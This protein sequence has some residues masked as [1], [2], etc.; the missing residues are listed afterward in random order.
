MTRRVRPADLALLALAVV[1]LV[2]VGLTLQR[3]NAPVAESA[4]G[5]PGGRPQV[6]GA[7]DVQRPP[8]LLVV[9]DE[10]AGGEGASSPAQGFARLLADRLDAPYSVDAEPDTG[11][12]ARGDEPGTDLS[13]PARVKRLV[14]R[15]GPAPDLVV[16]EGGHEDYAAAPGELRAAVGQV[17]R[18]LEKA[19][20]DAQVVLMGS[21]R[22]FPESEVLEPLHRT[23]A[24]GAEEAGVPFVDPV[25]DGWIDADN[26]ARLIS[27]DLFHPNDEG[28]ALLAER[29]LQELR[30]LPAA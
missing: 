6:V 28:H 21:T 15:G 26:T 27:G 12:V 1:V 2:F 8:R 18:R 23:L 3:F 4:G 9:G 19:Y 11:Y 29:L 22:A 7:Q 14:E 17:V 5:A 25:A 20:P 16:V 13:F 24:E 10:L 30:A